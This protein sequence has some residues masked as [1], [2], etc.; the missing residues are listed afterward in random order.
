M[1]Y[2]YV[3]EVVKCKKNYIMMYI[4]KKD[5]GADQVVMKTDMA[6]IRSVI[7]YGCITYG[8]AAKMQSGT[9]MGTKK[10]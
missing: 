7:D 2:T 9:D 10:N 1:A 6:L 5:W 3:K 4:R 8:Y